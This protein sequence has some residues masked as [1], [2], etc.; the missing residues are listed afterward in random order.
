VQDL[1]RVLNDKEFY[2]RF[3]FDKESVHFLVEEFLPVYDGPK[4]VHRMSREEKMLA[5]LRFLATNSFLQVC[6][7][8]LGRSKAAIWAAVWEVLHLVSR[9]AGDFVRWPTGEAL[10]R[11]KRLHYEASGIPNLIGSLDCT[12]VVVQVGELEKYA[13]QN[14]K[15]TTSINVEAVAGFDGFFYTF[16]ATWPGRTHDAF[17]LNESGFSEEFDQGRMGNAC[18]LG[19]S[20]YGNG[21]RWLL[22]P[23][24]MPRT[25]GQCR[26][27]ARQKGTRV[28][29]EQAFGALKRR[30]AALGGTLRVRRLDRAQAIIAAAFALQNLAKRRRQPDLW[31]A[32]EPVAE[33]DVAGAAQPPAGDVEPRAREGAHF[34]DAIVRRFFEA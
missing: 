17:I 6:G 27:N 28:K 29:V 18:L 9:R 20:G 22:T 13:F 32:E 2:E 33:E 3:R 30:W 34:R 12:H 26:Y 31:G 21:R 15:G 8:T 16:N 7:D 23:F 24:L 5:A 25:A 14:R 11:Q 19:D 4:R 1:F 10:E